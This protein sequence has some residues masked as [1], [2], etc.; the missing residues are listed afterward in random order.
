M[1]AVTG[2][3][4]K[5][6]GAV[7]NA[8]REAGLSVRAVVRDGEKGKPWAAKAAPLRLQASVMQTR[9]RRPFPGPMASS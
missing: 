9:S 5:V 4:R 7:A 6:G 8:L 1:Y 3:T 2:I